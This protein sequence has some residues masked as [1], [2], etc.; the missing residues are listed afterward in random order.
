[1]SGARLLE[2]RR[3]REP[4]GEVTLYVKGF[5]SRGEAPEQFGAWL[6]CH[7]VLESRAGWAPGALGYAWSSGSLLPWPAAAL[8][9]LKGAWD[10]FRILRNLRR[11]A[12]L[13][14]WGMLAAEEALLVTAHFVHQ[15]VA[16]SRSARANAE[17]Q[18]EQLR[19]L[20]ERHERVRVVA[21]SLGCRHV[22]E[23]VSR[24]PRRLR[25]HEIHL[26]AP[27]CREDEVASRLPRL[28]RESTRLYYTARDRVLDLA[29]TPLA[30]GRALGF[31]GPQ[32]RYAGLTALDVSDRFEFWVHGEYK[33]RFAD[34]VPPGPVA[35][36]L[37]RSA[38]SDASG[39]GERR[40]G[41]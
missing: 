15:Y 26:C 13:G 9:G 40:E 16:A 18:A 10:V 4:N 23:A 36:T 33:N 3:P 27:A 34:L 41:A 17:A 22:I 31:S 32:T 30:R 24:L 14:H 39:P 5:L 1:M 37:E 25:P 12:R 2:L 28:A 6:A 7:E 11:T 8:G 38:A 19:R 29:F 20:A 21:H 35:A